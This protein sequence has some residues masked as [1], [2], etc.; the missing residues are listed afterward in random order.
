MKQIIVAYSSKRQYYV[1]LIVR[2]LKVNYEYTR[3]DIAY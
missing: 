1:L 2:L 3:I